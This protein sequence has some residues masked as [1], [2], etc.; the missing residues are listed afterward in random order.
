MVLL[1]SRV[2]V[3]LAR[4]TAFLYHGFLCVRTRTLNLFL[5]WEIPYKVAPLETENCLLYV[6]H[7]IFVPEIISHEHKKYKL[8]HQDHFRPKNG[9]MIPFD[10]F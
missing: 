2:W 10:L 5:E 4:D 6:L 8:I 3:F 1:S 7:E 9:W